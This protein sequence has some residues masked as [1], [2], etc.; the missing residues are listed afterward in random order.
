[1]SFLHLFRKNDSFSPSFS[2]RFPSFPRGFA[3][4]FLTFCKKIEKH[5]AFPAPI[6]YTIN[7]HTSVDVCRRMTARFH[8][9]VLPKEKISQ[10]GSRTNRRT[11]NR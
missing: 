11:V 1:M 5:L 7:N 4:F 9:A 6:V 3:Y 2:C 8:I 10:V